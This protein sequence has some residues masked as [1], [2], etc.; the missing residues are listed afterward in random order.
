M[1]D[2]ENIK[3]RKKFEKKEIY[4]VPSDEFI[5]DDDED[6]YKNNFE[7]ILNLPEKQKQEFLDLRDEMTKE[8]PTIEKIM[9]SNITK[10]DKKQCL[11]LLDQLTNTDEYSAECFRLIDSIND[12]LVKG[13]NYTKEEIKFLEA[14]EEKLKK[15]YATTDT[16]KSKIL[17]LEAD[18]AIKAKILKMYDEMNTYPADS[19]TYTS[20]KEEIE[21]SIRMPYQKRQVDSYV[22]MNNKQLNEFYCK[23]RKLLDE[24]LY[25]MEK[26]K[27][28]IMHVLNDRRSSGDACG[29]N[30]ALVGKP[31]TGK[32]AICKVLAKILDKK[33]AKISAG[34]LDSAAIKGSNKV[35]IGSEPSIILQILASLKTNNAIIMFD[36]VDKLGDTAQGKLAQHAL[37]HVSDPSD[38]KDFQ[39]N[40]LK[41]FSHDLS[42]ILFIY[43]MNEDECLDNAL[44]DRFDI[45][46]VDE[47]TND[48]KFEIFKNYMLPKALMNIGMSKNDVTISD[49]AIKKL[50]SRENLGLRNIEKQIKN[51]IGKINMYKNIML[52]D[53]TTGNLKLDYNISNFKLPLKIDDKLLNEL[54]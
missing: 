4:R 47:Y 26:V 51:I 13:Q 52:P 5:V 40:Y 50:L 53:G 43:C 1:R 49:L 29:R 19:T 35:W 16:L 34:A 30:I 28:R 54:L 37:L 12:I 9:I 14:E 6:E 42:K 45:I 21:W 22:N 38:N 20:L 31:G 36:E 10:N 41:N 8:V 24:E 46:Y 3:K 7:T 32:T 48:E 17:K 39:D 27:N 44:K 15:M 2:K 33:F 18:P 23:V 11:R 25:G